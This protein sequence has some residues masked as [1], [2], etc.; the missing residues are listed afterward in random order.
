MDRIPY[1]IKRW[2][3]DISIAV[4]LEEKDIP[5]LETVIT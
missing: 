4:F 3:R 1:L 5:Q 2:K